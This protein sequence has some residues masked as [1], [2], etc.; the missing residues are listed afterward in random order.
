MKLAFGE[1]N[2]HANGLLKDNWSFKWESY[3]YLAERLYTIH[4]L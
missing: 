4:L 1:P 3:T 2:Q